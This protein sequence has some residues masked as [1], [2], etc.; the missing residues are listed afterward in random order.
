M[1]YP[2]RSR[3]ARKKAPDGNV[4]GYLFSSGFD[5]VGRET[6]ELLVVHLVDDRRERIELVRGITAHAVRHD[7]VGRALLLLERDRDDAGDRHF[8]QRTECGVHA[9]HLARHR[10]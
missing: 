8:L 4:G 5:D 9:Q 2:A 10:P 7:H 1:D 6:A 3:K